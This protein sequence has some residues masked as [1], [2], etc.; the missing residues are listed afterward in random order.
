MVVRKESMG[1]GVPVVDPAI[2]RA[3]VDRSVSRRP[4]GQPGDTSN[5]QDRSAART[6]QWQNKNGVTGS[7][8]PV[9]GWASR[10]RFAFETG[11]SNRMRN[12][13]G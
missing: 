7:S 3:R 5:S 2:E 11:T 8:M 13:R 4:A 12:E 10:A 6:F 1:D 9:N